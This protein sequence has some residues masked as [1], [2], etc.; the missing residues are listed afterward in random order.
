MD[1][2]WA[3]VYLAVSHVDLC[4]GSAHVRGE[5]WQTFRWTTLRIGSVSDLHAPLSVWPMSNPAGSSNALE[6]SEALIRR[7]LRYLSIG[8]RSGQN[9][10]SLKKKKNNMISYRAVSQRACFMPMK[11]NDTLMAYLSCFSCPFLRFS[12]SICRLGL[13]NNHFSNNRIRIG[14]QNINKLHI[15]GV[16]HP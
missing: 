8:R 2:E 4:I 14:M 1:G 10:D 7:Y 16:I 3:C 11:D 5:C 6:I 12:R 9:R 13:N 15:F